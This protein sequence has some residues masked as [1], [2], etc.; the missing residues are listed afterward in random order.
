MNETSPAMKLEMLSTEHLSYCVSASKKYYKASPKFF[1]EF[2]SACRA[3]LGRRKAVKL[4]RESEPIRFHVPLLVDDSEES[5]NYYMQATRFTAESARAANE[6]RD[7]EL[8]NFFFA[9]TA[10]LYDQVSQAVAKELS[11]TDKASLAD[12][13]FSAVH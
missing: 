10:I 7:W 5:E 13:Q 3:E 8:R 9:L 1:N 2:E 12:E 11:K 4:G 6:R